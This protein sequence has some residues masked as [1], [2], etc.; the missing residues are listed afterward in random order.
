[1]L[2][3]GGEAGQRIANAKGNSI[4][5]KYTLVYHGL[6]PRPDADPN[7]TAQLS[8]HL[9]G[10]SAMIRL[11]FRAALLSRGHDL[12]PSTTQIVPNLPEA[13]L[14]MS[15]LADRLELTLQR[16]GQLVQQL[17]SDG[18]LRRVPDTLDG[19]AKRVVYADRGLQLLGDVD[20]IADEITAEFKGILGARRFAS[21]CRDLSVL[22]RELRGSEPALRIP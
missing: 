20:G 5:S 6:M 22:D 17:E 7:D 8:R 19:R 9:I 11:R 12:S 15:Q 16:T 4:D 3:G 14:G 1:M 10:I 18:Y 13:G 21:L 2:L